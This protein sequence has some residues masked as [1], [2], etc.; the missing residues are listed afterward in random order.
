M[1]TTSSHSPGLVNR[2]SKSSRA[3]SRLAWILLTPT[4]VVLTVVIIIPIL[5]SLQQ[6]L[7]GKAGLDEETGFVSK[8]APFVGL[9]NYAD[10]FT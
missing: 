2:R 4:I 5:Q 10:I 9:K 8:V 7:Y 3:Q 1:S 6:S